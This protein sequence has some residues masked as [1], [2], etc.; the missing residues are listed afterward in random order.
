LQEKDG[1]EDMPTPTLRCVYVPS[2]QEILNRN[3]RPAQAH[4]D[5]QF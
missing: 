3:V 1:S 5:N 2:I 4:D